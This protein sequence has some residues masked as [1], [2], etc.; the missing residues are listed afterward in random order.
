MSKLAANLTIILGAVGALTT[1]LIA[2][3]VH[4]TAD[5]TAAINGAVSAAVAVVGVWFHPGIPVGNTGGV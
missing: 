1:L 4:I 3:G 2:F 5:Q